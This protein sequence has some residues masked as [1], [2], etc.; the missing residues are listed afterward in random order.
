MN[1][2][3]KPL[4]FS[5]ILLKGIS[6]WMDIKQ[7]YSSMIHWKKIKKMLEEIADF[8]ISVYIENKELREGK[9]AKIG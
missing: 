4:F 8:S 9:G 7:I 3:W 2:A 5:F 1:I 6:R